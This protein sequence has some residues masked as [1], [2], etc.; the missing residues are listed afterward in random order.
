M[1][2][3][4]ALRLFERIYATRTEL[5]FGISYIDECQSTISISIDILGALIHLASR[6]NLLDGRILLSLVRRDVLEG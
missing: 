1:S 3:R 4:A 2:V 5:P 6:R